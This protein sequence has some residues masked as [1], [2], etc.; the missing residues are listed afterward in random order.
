MIIN[1]TLS[2][3]HGQLQGKQKQQPLCAVHALATMKGT[4]VL[5]WCCWGAAHPFRITPASSK[6]GLPFSFHVT[7]LP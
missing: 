6:Q 5:L 2:L 7:S 4:R 3:H 1:D